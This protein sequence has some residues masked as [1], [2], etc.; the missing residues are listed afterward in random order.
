[1]AAAMTDPI[2][3]TT[4]AP[5]ERGEPGADDP[6]EQLQRAALEAIRTGRMILDA[7]EAIVQDPRTVE[8]L[9]RTVT[10]LA[11]AAG[12]TVATV[13]ARTCPGRPDGTGADHGDRGDG[14]PSGDERMTVG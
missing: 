9:L 12:E 7:A 13:A 8:L 11:R 6:I 10:D 5:D 1:M 4:D 2:D 14:G 3:A